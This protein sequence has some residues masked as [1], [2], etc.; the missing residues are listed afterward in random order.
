MKLGNF[1]VLFV[2]QVSM[3]LDT[4]GELAVV[5]ATRFTAPDF[6]QLSQL[7]SY[8]GYVPSNTGYFSLSPWMVWNTEYI[9]RSI[10]WI[11]SDTDIFRR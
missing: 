9:P 2:P 1:P 6:P 10:S 5:Q 7:S 3:I 11:P 8:A 4:T